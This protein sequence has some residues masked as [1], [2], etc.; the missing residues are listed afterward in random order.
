MEDFSLAGIPR[1]VPVVDNFCA[2]CSHVDNWIT[3]GVRQGYW[4]DIEPEWWSFDLGFLDEI[5]VTR[6]CALCRLVTAA[7]CKFML[8]SN[9]VA[10]GF[11]L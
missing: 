5:V 11:Q 8:D 3:A 4:R 10:R 2:P 1:D 9:I 6:K 7:I